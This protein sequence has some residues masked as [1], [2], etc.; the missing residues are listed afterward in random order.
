M[1]L[2]ADYVGKNIPTS[3]EEQVKVRLIET[4]GTDDVVIVRSGDVNNYNG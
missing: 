2:R 1:P 3:L 4:D